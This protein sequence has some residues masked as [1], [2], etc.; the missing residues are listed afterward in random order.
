MI[1]IEKRIKKLSFSP[2]PSSGAREDLD[3]SPLNMSLKNSKL[4]SI[5]ING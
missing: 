1:Q 3:Q 5:L 4:R 2:I